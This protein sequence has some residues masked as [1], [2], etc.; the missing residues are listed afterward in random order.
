ME[1]RITLADF[2]Y[3]P[4]MRRVV[5]VV[6]AFVLAAAC[7]GAT[8]TTVPGGDGGSSS[9]GS[10]SGASS[11]S[12]SSSGGGDSGKPRLEDLETCPGPG[13]CILDAAGCCGLNCQPDS[14]LIAVR[15]GT[16]EQVVAATC[17]DPGTVGCPKCLRQ[18]DSSIQAFCRAGTC[19]VVDVRTDP[20][21]SCASDGDCLLLYATCCQPCNGGPI[22][23]I[24]AIDQAGAGELTLQL[25]TGTETCDRCLPSFP[26]QLHAQCNLATGHCEV[27]GK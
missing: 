14:A 2:R 19:S 17:N 10:S 22:A 18:I 23:Q 15:R 25:C 27:A 16:A 1:S 9:G 12:G 11:S 4:A 21:S 13:Q 26:G 8:A 3:A 7:G 24:V 6:G 5:I 20:I